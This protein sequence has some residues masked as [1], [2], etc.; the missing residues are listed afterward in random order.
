MP[1]VRR[2][3]RLPY[4]A[5]G[6]HRNVL[7]PHLAA[8]DLLPVGASRYDHLSELF[9][10][11]ADSRGGTA[12]DISVQISVHEQHNSTRCNGSFDR[13]SFGD[14]ATWKLHSPTMCSTDR[15]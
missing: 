10:R 6:G 14:G 8:G 15:P 13:R 11:S 12:V 1:G 5:L 4:A 2:A 9:L 7:E 3:S